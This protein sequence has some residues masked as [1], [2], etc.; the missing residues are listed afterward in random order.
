MGVVARMWGLEIGQSQH[1]LRKTAESLKPSSGFHIRWKWLL[2]RRRSSHDTTRISPCLYESFSKEMCD[3]NDCE[4]EQQN[5]Q[6]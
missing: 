4:E 6:A 1:L 2:V 3:A 5:Q